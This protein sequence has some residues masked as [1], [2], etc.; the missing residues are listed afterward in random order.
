MPS[1]FPGMDPYV[2][3]QGLWESCHAALIACCTEVVNARLPQGYVARIATRIKVVTQE[4]PGSERIPE[5]LIGRETGAPRTSHSASGQDAGVATIKPI[6]IPFAL[7]EVEVRD[8]WIE[9][10]NLPEME[11]VTVVELL[12]PSNKAG[13]GRREYLEK[14]ASLIDG[15]VNFV[16]I[17]LLLAGRRMPMAKPLPP[18]D[19]YAVVGRTSGTPDAHVYAWTIRHALPAIPIPLHAPDADVFLDLQQAFDLTYDRGLYARLLRYG[20]PLPEALPLS[21]A[22]R[23]WSESIGL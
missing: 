16:E 14:R 2:E 5:V 6:T 12:S 3:A 4:I 10:L 1:P 9:I 13:N 18:G 22:E 8:R 23:E 15:T 7:G 11:L 20:R 19:Y 21:A 17:D